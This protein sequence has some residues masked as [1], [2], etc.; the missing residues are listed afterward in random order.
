LYPPPLYYWWVAPSEGSSGE[1]MGNSCTISLKNGNAIFAGCSNTTDSSAGFPKL[2]VGLYDVFVCRFKN[3]DSIITDNK[4]YH[5]IIRFQDTLSPLAIDE[6]VQPSPMVKVFPN[7]VLTDATIVVQGELA[8]KYWFNLYD[9]NGKSIIEG[10]ELTKLGHGQVVLHFA[11][12]NL[13]SGIY[14]FKVYDKNNNSA[15][16]KIIIE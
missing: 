12:G 13:Q 1:E 11:K 9:I 14:L 6:Q 16:G 8:D 15:T 5:K 10:K 2:S 3:C 4:L 7:P